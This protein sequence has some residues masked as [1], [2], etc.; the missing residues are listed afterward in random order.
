MDQLRA[1]DLFAYRLHIERVAGS[2]GMGTV[3][4]ARDSHTGERV[5]LKLLHESAGSRDDN[6]RFLREA[7]LLAELRHPGI[8]SYVAHGQPA[9]G[10]RY[11]VMEWLEGEA[12]AQR[13]LR[14]PLK[15]PDALLLI[16]RL[17]EALATAF[18]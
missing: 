15:V 9:G 1:G 11:L 17:G 3:Y 16:Q 18:V 13:L 8:V 5:A 4:Q 2:G 10:Q 14:G 7:Q 6:E 12:L